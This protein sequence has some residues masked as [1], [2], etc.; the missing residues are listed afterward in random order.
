[1]ARLGK[2]RD[3]ELAALLEKLQSLR[4]YIE[5][6]KNDPV[7]GNAV[8]AALESAG[9]KTSDDA[10]AAPASELSPEYAA[11]RPEIVS[12]ARIATRTTRAKAATKAKEATRGKTA[13]KAASKAAP[14]AIRGKAASK[15]APKATGRRSAAQVKGGNEVAKVAARAKQSG[16]SRK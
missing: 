10:V 1:M 14:K 11:A 6:L 15:A 9:Y 4:N 12:R 8:S 16:T 7:I 13:S 3:R 2:T 5:S